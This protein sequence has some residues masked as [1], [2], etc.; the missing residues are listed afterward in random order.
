MKE[1]LKALEKIIAEL[2]EKDPNTASAE[3]IHSD[4]AII[5]AEKG[6]INF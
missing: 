4:S 6:F 1:D 2:K 5:L 3:D